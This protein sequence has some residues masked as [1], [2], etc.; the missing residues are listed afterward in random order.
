MTDTIPIPWEMTPLKTVIS[1]FIVPMRDKP[2]SFDSGV[3]W[4]RIEDFK[5]RTVDRSSSGREVNDKTIN[6]LSL[7]IFPVGTVLCSCSATLG[8]CA[9]VGKPLISNQTFIGL[10][11]DLSLIHI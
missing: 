2:K 7:K 10:V 11:P 1:E 6:E 4:V 3:P 5:G 8:I 9:I